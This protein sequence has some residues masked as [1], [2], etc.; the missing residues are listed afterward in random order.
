MYKLSGFADEIDQSLDNQMRTIKDL[1]MEWIECRGVDGAPLI[2]Y[3]IEDAEKIRKRLD[4]NGIKLSS[5][6]TFRTLQTYL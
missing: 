2:S 3:S 5:R 4:A 6:A 1:G